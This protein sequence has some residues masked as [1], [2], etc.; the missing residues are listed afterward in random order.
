[1]NYKLFSGTKYFKPVAVGIG[2][3]VDSHFGIFVADAAHGF[4]SGMGCL[5]VVCLKSEVKFVVAEVVGTVHIPHPGQFQQVIAFV[6]FQVDDDERAVRSGNS[7]RFLHIQR[8]R[9][10]LEAF[11]KIENIEIIVDHSEFHS[12]HPPEV[13][14]RNIAP[15]RRKFNPQKIRKTAESESL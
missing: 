2:N 12:R 3:E 15:V 6:A 5:V 10:E 11:V 4:V 14:C 7:P 9:I 8:F 13:V 1:M